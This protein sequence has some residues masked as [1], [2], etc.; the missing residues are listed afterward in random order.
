M[1]FT[2]DSGANPLQRGLGKTLPVVSLIAATRRSS[3]KWAKTR[4]EEPDPVSDVEEANERGSGIKI[5][6]MQTTVFG[7]PTPDMD[8]EITVK[9]KKRKRRE[10][11]DQKASSSRRSRIVIRSKATLL[12]CPMST[13]TNWEEQIK[14]HWDGHVEIVGGAAGV[15]PPKNIEKKWK[16]PKNGDDDDS[17]DEDIFDTLRVY[18]YHG[19]SRRSDPEFI[20]TFDVVITSYNTLALE[21]TKQ[22]S[23]GADETLTTPGETAANSG[24][25]WSVEPFSGGTSITSAA[26]KPEV[27]AEIKAVEV[28]D[29]LRQP[30]KK[31]KALKKVGPEQ[32][33]PLQAID[34]FRVVLD[35]AQYVNSP[36]RVEKLTVSSYIK[37]ASTVACQAA[38][39]LAADRRICLTG[40]PIQNKIEDVWAL[41][42]FLR[43]SPIDQKECFTKYISNPCKFGEQIGVARLQLVM[44]A[45]TLRRTKDSTAE[46]GRRIL[47]LPARKEMQLWLDLREDERKAYDDRASAVKKRVGELQANNDLGRNYA[48]V[49]QEVLRLR[50]I[51]DHVDLAKSGAVEEDYDGTI[52]DYEVAVQGIERYGITLA[53]AVSVVCFLKD[54]DGAQCTGCGLDYADFFPSLGLGGVEEDDK[55]EQDGPKLRKLTHKPILTKCLHIYCE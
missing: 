33:S 18:I 47:N 15:M 21:F 35:E 3:G 51:C 55:L 39:Q 37:S 54:G 45:C 4:R 10:E 50:Q 41:F 26:V 38:C 2:I 52:M 22:N 36:R 9:G 46:D 1:S 6:E 19:P 40:T 48:D 42:K 43:V 23:T 44:R 24:D 30:K 53:R 20:A 12:V 16:P 7:M 34:W 5:S 8:E 31:G 17:D 27:E 29:V 11:P 13:I 49:L 28:A 14:E 32:T 25:E